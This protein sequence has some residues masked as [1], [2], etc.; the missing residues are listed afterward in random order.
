MTDK[1]GHLHA[2]DGAAIDDVDLSAY[3]DG[4]LD[5]A[6]RQRV[7]AAIEGSGLVARRAE[8]FGGVDRAVARYADAMAAAALPARLC[9]RRMAAERRAR[10][11]RRMATLAAALALILVGAGGGWLG[12]GLFHRQSFA[13]RHFVEAATAAYQVYSVEIRHP[14][15]VAREDRGHMVAWLSKRIDHRLPAPSLD[16][17]GF[18]LVGGR[19]LPTRRGGA[20][21]QVMYEDAEGRRVTLYAAR[22]DSGARQAIRFFK[23]DFSDAETAYWFEPEIGYA[24]TGTVDR[25]TLL[26]LA[27]AILEGSDGA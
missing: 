14:V 23:A 12:H 19:L 18:R 25:E 20:A 13:V 22:N 16:A 3:L 1:N 11:T 7:A 4:E 8:L 21:A 5:P 2:E 27:N 26:K 15:E 9:V 10:R 17:E 24:L 6:A